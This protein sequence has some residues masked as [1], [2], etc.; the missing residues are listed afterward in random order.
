MEPCVDTESY[1]E[2]THV[3]GEKPKR[4]AIRK[5]EAGGEAETGKQA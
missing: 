1:T 2:R 3:D 5:K 4:S